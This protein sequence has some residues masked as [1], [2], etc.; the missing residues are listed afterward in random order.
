MILTKSIA[1]DIISNKPVNVK[2][3]KFDQI[4]ELTIEGLEY[5]INNSKEVLSFSNVKNIDIDVLNVFRKCKVNSHIYLDGLS[6]LDDIKAEIIA[7]MNLSVSLNGLKYISKSV[8]SKFAKREKNNYIGLHLNGLV[9]I[10]DDTFEELTKIPIDVLKLDGIEILT[11]NMAKSVIKN[12]KNY[13]SF[14]GIKTLDYRIAEILK[15]FKGSLYLNGLET[16]DD[17]S[18]NALIK[19]QGKWLDLPIK[20][21]QIFNKSVIIE[22][23]TDNSISIYYV[24]LKLI[25]GVSYIY[26]TG[27]SGGGVYSEFICK[28]IKE[29]SNFKIYKSNFITYDYWE[30][31]QETEKI[32]VN[33][34]LKMSNIDKESISK[35]LQYTKDEWLI[36]GDDIQIKQENLKLLKKNYFYSKYPSDDSTQVLK[37]ISKKW[38][39]SYRL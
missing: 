34:N 15:K 29:D 37:I 28:Y 19:F 22:S 27:N 6:E 35:M 23:N 4:S 32:I 10:D 39:L 21:H 17:R 8:A 38:M 2:Y 16:I 7:S 13:L 26:A 14:G 30:E 24:I 9:K 25:D 20:I 5:I 12:Y 3:I 36:Y 33:E 1:E 31:Y 11:E 18:S